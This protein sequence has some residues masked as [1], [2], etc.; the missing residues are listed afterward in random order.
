VRAVNL[1]PLACPHEDAGF[2]SLFGEAVVD[3]RDDGEGGAM[4]VAEAHIDPVI[5]ETNKL[6]K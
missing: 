6:I 3:V 2:T 1:L 4:W 5:S